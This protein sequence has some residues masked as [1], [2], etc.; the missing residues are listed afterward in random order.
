MRL[1]VAVQTVIRH[2]SHS[3]SHGA[4]HSGSDGNSDNESDGD[5]HANIPRLCAP[6][7]RKGWATLLGEN[8]RLNAVSASERVRI[9]LTVY[10]L[11]LYKLQ[12]SREKHGESA[13]FC[14][15]NLTKCIL[16]VHEV[17]HV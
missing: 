15:Q 12:L 8:H 17:H 11:Q 7:A 13:T 4:S 14:M 10:K 2:G 6:S 16:G 3:D 1:I 5:W 9:T